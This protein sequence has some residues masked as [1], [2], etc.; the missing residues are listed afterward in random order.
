MNF[1]DWMRHRGLSDSSTAKYAGAIQGSLSE[2]AMENG[3]TDGP[4]TAFRSKAAFFEVSQK[5]HTLDIFK[6]RNSR[7]HHMYS[8]ALTKYTEYLSEGYG[9]DLEEDIDAILAD[10][11]L[12]ST[13]RMSL[14]KSRVG[15][16]LFRQKLLV[17]WKAC[18]VTGFNDTNLLIASHIKPWRS[19]DNSERLNPFNGLLLTPN[20]DRA[21]DGGLITFR[22]DGPILISPLL[23][24]PDK[25]GISG[26][27]RIEIK[28]RHQSFM[29]FHRDIVFRAN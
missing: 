1:E 6:Q 26:S 23:S 7:G 24:E 2:W 3:I 12:S 21:F 17:H 22:Q 4:L 19:S 18:A 29:Q 16:G 9:S 8:S 14:V 13:E 20:L 25:L 5:I 28:E 15:Q 11:H 27:M 10:P